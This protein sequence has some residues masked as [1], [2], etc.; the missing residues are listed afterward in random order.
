MDFGI[1]HLSELTGTQTCVTVVLRT[2]SCRFPGRALA[3]AARFA[4]AFTPIGR[5]LG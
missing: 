1:A 4:V 3:Y 5:C 2:T